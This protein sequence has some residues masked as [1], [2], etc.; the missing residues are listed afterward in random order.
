M[1]YAPMEDTNQSTLKLWLLQAAFADGTPAT[2]AFGLSF[3]MPIISRTGIKFSPFADPKNFYRITLKKDPLTINVESFYHKLDPQLQHPYIIVTTVF[4]RAARKEIS[5][6]IGENCL[7]ADI[8][9]TTGMICKGA[10]V[11][12]LLSVYYPKLSITQLFSMENDPQIK[13]LKPLSANDYITGNLLAT[14]NFFETNRD[15]IWIHPPTIED[16]DVEASNRTRE[17]MLLRQQIARKNLLMRLNEL[18][19]KDKGKS[20]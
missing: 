14:F 4:E 8:S 19:I 18:S 5:K 17:N 20:T 7:S 10:I 6:T 12:K 2:G 16:A 3:D 11:E 9:K 13:G 1:I 15:G